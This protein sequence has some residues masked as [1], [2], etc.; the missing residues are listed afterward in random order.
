[1][2]DANDEDAEDLSEGSEEEDFESIPCSWKY[3]SVCILLPCLNGS[4]NGFVWPGYS[5]HYDAMG[6]S[7]VRAGLAVTVGF[8][9]RMTT[10]QMQLRGWVLVDCASC[11]HSL[12]LCRF[13]LGL[14]NQ[15][16]GRVW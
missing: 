12:D 16:V 11:L 15:R 3:V 14:H 10:Q 13:G 8:S 7:L 4:L 6:W 5:L 1:M 2:T 9:V